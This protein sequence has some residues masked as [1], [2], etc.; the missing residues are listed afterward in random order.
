MGPFEER[1]NA[2]ARLL[3]GVFIRERRGVVNSLG[4]VN[5]PG[6]V[7]STARA[8]SLVDVARW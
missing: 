1:P 6:V 4:I 2:L 5:V 7:L 8:P 3:P